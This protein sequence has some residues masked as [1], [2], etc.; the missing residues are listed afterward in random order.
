M[1]SRY[2]FM[3]VIPSIVSSRFPRSRL[4]KE[5]LRGAGQRLTRRGIVNRRRIVAGLCAVVAELRV[6]H[7][8]HGDDVRADGQLVARCRNVRRRKDAVPSPV[9]A[10]HTQRQT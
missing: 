1:L 9:D 3:T 4:G 10:Q 2:S 6:I 7:A 5:G 8:W